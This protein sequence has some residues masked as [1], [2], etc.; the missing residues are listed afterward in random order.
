[1][2]NVSS[3]ILNLVK[4]KFIKANNEKS[5]NWNENTIWKELY[6]TVYIK[7]EIQSYLIPSLTG[8]LNYFNIK[9]KDFF[10]CIEHVK[11]LDYVKFYGELGD[12]NENFVNFQLLLNNKFKNKKPIVIYQIDDNYMT[13]KL[14][15]QVQVEN[16]NK[17]KKEEDCDIIKVKARKF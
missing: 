14:A 6:S 12:D 3:H 7:N 5:F 1:M 11:N 17:R 15:N 16:D 4:K 10:S 8:L 13:Q 9:S 2:A